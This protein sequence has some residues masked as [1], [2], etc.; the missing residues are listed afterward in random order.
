MMVRKLV[1]MLAVGLLLGLGLGGTAAFHF[2][3]ASSSEPPASKPSSQVVPAELRKAVTIKV[4]LGRRSVVVSAK[5]NGSCPSGSKKIKVSQVGPRGPKGS[6]GLPGT[7]GE[8]GAEGPAG[9]EGPVGPEGP[10]GADGSNTSEV[11][12]GTP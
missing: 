6:T 4:C 2:A 12:G 5:R 9:P 1:S 8:P 7:P 11:D 10:P 3:S